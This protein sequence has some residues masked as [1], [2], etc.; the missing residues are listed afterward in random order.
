M[1]IKQDQDII[2]S[3]FEDYSGLRGGHAETVYIPEKESEVAELLSGLNKTRAKI[4][5]SGAGTSVTGA[6]TP[7]GGSVLSLEALNKIVSIKGNA[8]E[9]GLAVVQAGVRLEDLKK[10]ADGKGFLYPPDPTEQSS[11][12]GGNIGTN[13]SGSRGLRFGSTRKYV[14]KLKVVL[15]SGSMLEIERGKIFADRDGRLAIPAGS[16][17]PSMKL[18]V[19]SYEVPDIK[20]AAGYYNKSGMDLIDLFIGQEGTLGVITEAEVML[21]PALFKTVA[22]VGFFFEKEDAWRF[23]AEAKNELNPLSLEYLD[24]NSLVLLKTTYGNIPDFA[25]AAM[26]FEQDVTAANESELTEKWSQLLQKNG[27]PIEETWFAAGH[28]DQENFKEFRHALPEKV[29]NIIC[30]NKFPKVGSDLAVPARA[31]FEMMDFYYAKLGASKLDYLIFGHIGQCHLHANI[32]PATGEQFE[33]AK[34][35][36][37][38]LVE[39]ALSLGGTV[40]AEHGIGKLKHVYLEKMIGRAGMLEIARVKKALDPNFIL[41]PGNIIPEELLTQI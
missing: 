10:G 2:R 34:L 37:I 19:P 16:A 38:E 31:F 9:G 41:G 17:T 29:N 3:Y 12:I 27:A 22:G 11:F 36:Y 23:A 14:S 33:K 15:A 30:V 6:R 4:T 40:S 20:N 8:G 13:A 24:S 26:I 5:V 7:F 1:I 32:L 35:V 18:K 28:K 25:R 39:K 21:V